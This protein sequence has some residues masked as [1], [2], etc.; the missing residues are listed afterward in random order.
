MAKRERRTFSKEFKEQIKVLSQ[1]TLLLNSSRRK[2]R[3]TN[4]P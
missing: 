4:R 2:P 1:N 3:V